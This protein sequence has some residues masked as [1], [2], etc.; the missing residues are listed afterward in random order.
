V[1]CAGRRRKTVFN[2]F[3][4]LSKTAE[5]VSSPPPSSYTPLKQ[6]VNE[7]NRFKRAMLVKHSG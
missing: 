3:H 7:K 5:A 4:A 6:G 2:G 1:F